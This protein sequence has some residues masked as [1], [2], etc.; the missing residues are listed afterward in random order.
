MIPIDRSFTTCEDP[1][2]SGTKSI[3][4]AP[5][6]LDPIRTTRF[7]WLALGCHVGYAWSCLFL[8]RASLSFFVLF[9]FFVG[10]QLQQHLALTL[11][12][13]LFEALSK[14]AKFLKL[15]L[16]L[17]SSAQSGLFGGKTPH[18]R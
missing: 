8:G 14:S 10:E 11:R 5:D 13:R 7:S 12:M 9:L 3:E 4:V 2:Q 15:S 1:G 17:Q 16:R 6:T 18:S